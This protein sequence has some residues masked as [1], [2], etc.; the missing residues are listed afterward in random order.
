MT[1]ANFLTMWITYNTR[2]L[3]FFTG[4]ATS[5]MILARFNT[6]PLILT[7]LLI[8]GY[9]DIVN[10]RRIFIA[11]LLLRNILQKPASKFVEM[12]ILRMVKLNIL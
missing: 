2:L 7:I 12:V 11:E 8:I 4:L 9:T 10:G 3:I 1:A 6:L 5:L